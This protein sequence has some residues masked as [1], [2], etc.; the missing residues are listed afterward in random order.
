LR[1]LLD[2]YTIL[3]SRI[4]DPSSSSSSSSELSSVLEQIKQDLTAR[5]PLETNILDRIGDNPLA[6][7]V[8]KKYMENTG[9]TKEE[10]LK[11]L[12]KEQNVRYGICRLRFLL[13]V[14]RF[15]LANFLFFPLSCRLSFG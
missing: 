5:F 1:Y 10:Y 14:F 6:I 12:D 9:I 15:L 3:P 7:T 13:F 4:V 8:A 2:Q 11:L